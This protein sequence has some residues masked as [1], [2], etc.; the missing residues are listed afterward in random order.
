[1]KYF[2]RIFKKL[3]NLAKIY[4]VIVALYHPLKLLIIFRSLKKTRF[5][6]RI[7]PYTLSHYPKLGA[8][9]DLSHKIEKSGI[10]G[11]FIKCGVYY[12]GSAAIH[13]YAAKDNSQRHLWLFDSFEGLPEPG[14]KDV[15]TFEGEEPEKG[16]YAL[17]KDETKEVLFQ[18]MGLDE[19]RIHIVKGWFV[20]TLPV[21]ETGSIALLHLDADLYESTKTCLEELY[22][23][24]VT[25]GCIMTDDYAQFKGCREA[26]HEF[27]KQ[28]GLNVELVKYGSEGRE[29]VYI[30]KTPNSV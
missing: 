19:T 23:N 21:T 13:A 18:R 12:G 7:E 17:S 4:H 2:L 20:D 10:N 28:R 26:I 6:L 25:N 8:L 5:I 1:M 27:I 14:K 22:D 11:S 29:G 24:V 3:I 15:V 16:R 30:Y 9:Y